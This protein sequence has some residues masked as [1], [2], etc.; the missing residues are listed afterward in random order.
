VSYKINDAHEKNKF[1]NISA[2]NDRWKQILDANLTAAFAPKHIDQVKHYFSKGQWKHADCQKIKTFEKETLLKSSSIVSGSPMHNDLQ[3]IIA[4]IDLFFAM[5]K[6]A[7]GSPSFGYSSKIVDD[8]KQEL[9][10]NDNNKQVVSNH[11]YLKNNKGLIGDLDKKAERIREAF[12]NKLRKQ[13]NEV[14]SGD[15]YEDSS[16]LNTILENSIN[17]GLF[18][19]NAIEQFRQWQYSFY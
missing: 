19:S 4:T 15:S 12:F 7:M 18:D 2:D 8:L 13:Y 17:T 11:A 16:Q 10:I 5:E 1:S 9:G 3:E 6:Y 14:K